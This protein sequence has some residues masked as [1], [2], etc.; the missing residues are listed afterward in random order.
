M[1]IDSSNINILVPSKIKEE[2]VFSDP[3]LKY[4][5]SIVAQKSLFEKFLEWVTKLFFDKTG[6]ENI[7][8]ARQIIIWS[9]V[10]ISIGIIIWLL[11]KSEFFSL[12]KPKP[13][14]TSFN[15]T[16][17]TDDLNAINFN[18]KIKESLS[19]NDYRLAIRWHYLKTLF[20]LDKNQLIVFVPFKTNIDYA[21]ELQGK[22]IQ[23]DFKKLS[24]IYE[25]IWY[26]QF[27]LDEKAYHINA[28]EFEAVEKQINV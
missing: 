19:Q 2:K 9:V 25:Y 14:A 23:S 21:N 1:V 16:D 18:D 22:S 5:H 15:F 17:I 20:I 26:G 11:S 28:A 27:I 10:A 8:K 24:R 12:I 7:Y 4:G 3:K 6:Y 13:K